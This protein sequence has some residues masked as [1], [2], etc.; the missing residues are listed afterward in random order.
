V[1][2]QLQSIEAASLPVLLL[3]L[4][5]A[6]GVVLVC[7]VRLTKLADRF[8]DET[9][10][11]EAVIGAVFLGA[12]TSLPGTVTSITA[13]YQGQPDLALS[14]AVG[15]IAAQTLFLVLADA[16]YPR[17]NL[18]HA[19]ASLPNMITGT[20]LILLLALVLAAEALPPI[21]MMGI[22]PLTPVL[23]LLY[24][25]GIKIAAQSK[26]RPMWAPQKTSET[27]EDVPE[28]PKRGPRSRLISLAQLLV[29]G[30]IL[31]VAGHEIAGL[32]L[33][34]ADRTQIRQGVVGALLTAVSTSTPELVTTV[35]AVRRGALTLA[36]GGILGGNAFDV[37]F[38]AFS[39]IAY[40]S[41]SI[42]HA[43]APGFR[44]LVLISIVMTAILLLGLLR[45]ERRGPANI[46]VD[47]I[48]LILVYAAGMTAFVRLF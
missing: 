26:A 15:G 4:A 45:R 2:A 16:A 9:G 37:L 20:L 10:L 5:I 46:G 38:A 42:Y 28:A 32:G 11:G 3:L 43:D 29:L 14:N 31:G 22:H 48:M 8:A 27:R 18:E 44:F 25:F 17:V 36:V 35:A 13:A 40:G 34:I 33:E 21:A 7:G 41:G 12:L 1:L 30:L 24:A 39:D 19:A 47:G 23:F 6:T